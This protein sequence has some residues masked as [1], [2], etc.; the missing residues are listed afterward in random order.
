MKV[1]P[2]KQDYFL[3]FKFFARLYLIQ[4]NNF[5][6]QGKQR[7]N[8]NYSKYVFLFPSLSVNQEICL[9]VKRPFQDNRSEFKS[10]GYQPIAMK[11]FC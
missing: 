1:I 7:Q 10:I 3:K 2:T 9:I 5:S 11:W 6:V 8:E 4:G